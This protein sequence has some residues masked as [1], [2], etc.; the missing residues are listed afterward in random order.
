MSLEKLIESRIQDA[1]AAGAFSDLRGAGRPLR[2]TAEA[3]LAGEN[4]MGFKILQNGDM[5]PV[6]LMLAKE[7][8]RETEQLDALE[9]RHAEWVDLAASSGEWER[10][11]GALQRLRDRFASQARALR[12][13]QDQFNIDAPSL[14]LERPQIWVELRL[15]R[16]DERLRTAGAPESVVEFTQLPPLAR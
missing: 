8:E 12:R 1:I 15:E 2:P 4:W 6:W 5:L 16:L 7:I 14:A 3:A 10:H 13:K 11:A 9:G